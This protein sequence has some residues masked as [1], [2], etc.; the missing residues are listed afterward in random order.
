[1]S[2]GSSN[3]NNIMNNILDSIDMNPSTLKLKKRIILQKKPECCHTPKSSEVSVLNQ[4]IK[5]SSYSHVLQ[6]D[7]FVEIKSDSLDT[8]NST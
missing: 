2:H 1:I 4:A 8:L 7:K 5:Y 3:R 6:F